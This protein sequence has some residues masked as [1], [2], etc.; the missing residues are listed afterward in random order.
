MQRTRAEGKKNEN[1]GEGG[2]GGEQRAVGRCLQAV[3]RRNEDVWPDHLRWNTDESDRDKKGGHA[4][5][6]K[7]GA[8]AVERGKPA[9]ER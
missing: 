7:E 5:T 4:T 6:G 9:G 3:N 1:K 2:G 8:Q